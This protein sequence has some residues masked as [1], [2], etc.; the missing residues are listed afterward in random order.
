LGTACRRLCRLPRSHFATTR[1]EDSPHALLITRPVASAAFSR[2]CGMVR[3]HPWSSAP[4]L[5]LACLLPC[6]VALTSSSPYAPHAAA[7][8]SWRS[9]SPRCM[10]MR[11]PAKHGNPLSPCVSVF[12]ARRH[13][14]PGIVSSATADRL[15]QT[16][17]CPLRCLTSAHPLVHPAYPFYSCTLDALEKQG[18]LQRHS[19]CKGRLHNVRIPCT[20]GLRSV[21]P[22][23][24]LSICCLP[25][26]LAVQQQPKAF[27]YLSIT[28]CLCTCLPA[29]TAPARGGA[30]AK[31]REAAI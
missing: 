27:I 22:A 17:V 6:T 18:T 8:I 29:C 4:S 24:H 20:S 1:T 30:K 15:Q 12:E 16:Q 28:A 21:G 25:V 26:C 23:L 5:S 9:S 31:H 3:Q 14:I 19:A 7:G 11:V 13:A 2:L 10:P